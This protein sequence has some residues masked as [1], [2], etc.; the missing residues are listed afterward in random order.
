MVSDGV[1]PSE[2]PFPLD[3]R[4]FEKRGDGEVLHSMV[5]GTYS[6]EIRYGVG[7]ALV[8]RNPVVELQIPAIL[9]TC[10]VGET[11]RTLALVPDNYLV[12]DGGWD[13][14]SASNSP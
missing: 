4:F 10:P 5:S 2:P 1:V 12:L 8:H 9:T 6:R 3:K 14:G 11:Y 7:P 13:R